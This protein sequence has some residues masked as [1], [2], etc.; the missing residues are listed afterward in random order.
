[1]SGGAQ[2]TPVSA[3]RHGGKRW[4]RFASY[5]FVQDHPLVPIVLGEHEQ[6]AASL[7]IVFAPLPG[8]LWPV[9]LTRLGPDCALVAANGVWRGAYV[10]SVLR[11]HP[12][13]AQVAKGTE[14]VLMVDEGSGLVTEDP[15][16]EPFFTESGDLAPALAQVLEFF[17]TRAQAELR[18][19]A[20]MA[21]ILRAGLLQPFAL[22]PASA[23]PAGA[24]LEVNPERLAALG[25][26]ELAGLH[27]T[28]ALGLVHAAGVAR[29]HLGFL[30]QAEEF[31]AQSC[32][33]QAPSARPAIS[34]GVDPALA[35]F[36]DALANAQALDAP[37]FLA[38][39]KAGRG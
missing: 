33:V 30:A 19:R 26:S 1:M 21:E 7:P 18:T 29:H 17:R 34:G 12:F 9:A 31:A 3:A 38:G 16:D 20:A 23:R 5:S 36:F 8:G 2:L 10:P 22:R 28:G 32:G 35:G 13:Q 39:P 4:R 37:A 24:M 27:R 25:R 14:F 15:R 11:V 6:V